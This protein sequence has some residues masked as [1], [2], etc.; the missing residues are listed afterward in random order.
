MKL[1]CAYGD[2][3]LTELWSVTDIVRPI[4]PKTVN[5][6]SPTGS[7]GVVLMG[8]QYGSYEISL[9]VWA[10]VPYMEQ[11]PEI[12]HIAHVFDARKPQQLWFSDE[13]DRYRMAIPQGSPEV[14][15]YIDAVSVKV[16]L[17]VPEPAMYGHHASVTVPSG[18]SVEFKVGGTYPTQ[19]KIVA[20]SAVRS[21]SSLV[22]GVRLDQGDVLKVPLA[23]S[24]A[25]RI[26]IDCKER[27]CRIANAPAL[28]TL[29]SD[30][31]NLTPGLHTLTNHQGSGACTIEWDERWL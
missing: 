18:S 1:E 23:F 12:A 15:R 5:T 28:P 24:T 30:W 4:A 9:T 16:S 6:E 2:V 25:R 3:M 11:A 26:E 13:L 20:G 17:L 14:T 29:D 19:P 8:V 10:H 21:P 31:F 27:E 22:W 7:D